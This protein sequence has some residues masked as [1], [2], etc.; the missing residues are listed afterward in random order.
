MARIVAAN[1]ATEAAAFLREVVEPEVTKA[2]WVHA[3]RIHGHA[4][5]WSGTRDGIPAS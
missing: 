3:L 4:V 5:G 1:N 2:G